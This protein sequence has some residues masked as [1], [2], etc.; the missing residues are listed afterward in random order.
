MADNKISHIRTI[1]IFSSKLLFFCFTLL[2]LSGCGSGGSAN[3]PGK[4]PA[5]GASTAVTDDWYHP[6]LNVTWQ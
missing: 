3:D 4:A 2:L 5:T 6:P 1:A